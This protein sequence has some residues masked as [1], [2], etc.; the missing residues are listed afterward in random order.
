[1]G[2]YVID[3]EHCCNLHEINQ[4]FVSRYDIRRKNQFYVV[5]TLTGNMSAVVTAN[6]RKY[7]RKD[8]EQV[9]RL[10]LQSV[11]RRLKTVA[12]STRPPFVVVPSP[13][14]RT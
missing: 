7:S 2:K 5:T 13:R 6:R 14:G 9:E 4:F 12:A 10:L 1:M 3:V 11:A 8:R